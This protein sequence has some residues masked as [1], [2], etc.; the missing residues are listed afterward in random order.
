ME[1]RYFVRSPGVKE[2]PV[3]GDLALY[4]GERRA[5][6]VLNSTARFIWE[7]LLDPVTFDELLF[8]LGEAFVD[9]PDDVLRGDL[10]R[11]LKQF[12]DLG[13]IQAESGS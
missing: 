5:I 12:G 3:G 2:K 9:I 11:T 8:M 13:L 10:D 1:T 7:S 4:V 6:H